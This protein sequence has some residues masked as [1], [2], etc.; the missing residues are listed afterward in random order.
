MASVKQKPLNIQRLLF[1]YP[2]KIYNQNY[3]VL[4]NLKELL[5]SL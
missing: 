4:N 3:I 5:N 1:L 2:V